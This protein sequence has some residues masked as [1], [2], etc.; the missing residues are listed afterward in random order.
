MIVVGSFERLQKG[1]KK[2]N[3]NTSR[4]FSSGLLVAN[5]NTSKRKKTKHGANACLVPRV[6]YATSALTFVE[7]ELM[8]E[9]AEATY[10]SAP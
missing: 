1:G 6:R 3:W 5:A 10:C 8:D 2:G 9:A 7:L 4:I